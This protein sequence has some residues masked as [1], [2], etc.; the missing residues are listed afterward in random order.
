M[1]RPEVRPGTIVV[2][3][4]V[5]CAWSTVA[6][7]RLLRAR[8]ELDLVDR[9]HL[10]HR[11]FLLEDVN[12]FPIPKKFLDSEIPVV[13]ALEPDLGWKNWQGD[14][15]DWPVTTAPANEAVHAA[16]EQSPR[17]AEE[18]DMALRLALFRDSRCV[19]LRHEIVDIA[20]NCEHVDADALGEALDDGRAR[21]PMMR[22]YRG[23]RD[24]VQGSPHL[25]FADGHDVHNPGIGLRWVGE[26]GAGFP[27]VEHDDPGIFADLVRRAA[28]TAA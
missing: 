14:P 2:Y 13:G 9:V 28:D 1:P 8:D 17:A 15:A 5:A 26:Q 24:A 22:D 10:D 21:G 23:N 16:K 20:R 12:A 27:V 18:L 19:S 25:F 4:D 6:I 3:T 7:V 11:C